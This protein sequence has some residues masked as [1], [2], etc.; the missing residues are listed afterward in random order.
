MDWNF[1]GSIRFIIPGL[2]GIFLN[3]FALGQIKPQFTQYIYNGLLLN[4]AITGIEDYTDLRFGFRDQWTG[5]QDAPKTFFFTVQTPLG[6]KNTHQTPTSFSQSLE[7]ITNEEN[8]E[9]LS[10]H[11]GIGFIAIGDKYGP[12]TQL[13]VDISYAYHIPLSNRTSLALGFSGGIYEVG[14]NTQSLVLPSGILADPSVKS[15]NRIFPDLNLGLFLYN[16]RY[17][18]GASI[19]NIIDNNFGSDLIINSGSTTKNYFFTAGYKL[20]LSRTFSLLPSILFKYYRPEP[21]SLD[22]N[23]KAS[24]LDRI[25][26]GASVRQNDSFSILAG[27]NISPLYNIGYSYDYTT[28]PLS[29]YVGGTHEIFIGFLINNINHHLCPRNVW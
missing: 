6:N 25:W 3:S 18:L 26:L 16:R 19:S 20:Y 15:N 7:G 13:N 10:P 4:P 21:A 2:F 17:F 28:S 12:F 22:I 24:Y 5:I 29:S 14:L 23:L 1:R 9:Y 8:L 27:I 11:H